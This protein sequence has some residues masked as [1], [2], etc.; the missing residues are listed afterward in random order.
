MVDEF[1]DDLYRS[2][3]E[4]TLTDRGVPR[5][6]L[7]PPL[8]SEPATRFVDVGLEQPGSGAGRVLVGD[9][10]FEERYLRRGVI[11][12][13]GMGEVVLWRDGRV[14]RDVAV[15]TLHEE[16]KGD[17]RARARFLREARVQGQLEH[18]SIVP[19]YDLRD[20]PEHGLSFTMKRVR[21]RTL[22][23]IL[24]ERRTE[25][26]SSSRPDGSTSSS[27]PTR[28]LLI[29]LSSVC[30]AI[31]FAHQRGVVH[32]D[33]KPGNVMLGD[34][35]E[36]YVLDWGLAKVSGDIDEIAG[37]VEQSPALVT[38][39]GAVLG[40]LGYMAPEQL[41]ASL[42]VVGPEADVYALGAIL[43]EILTNRPLIA[44]RDSTELALKTL[45]G[46]NANARERAPELEVPPELEDVCVQ[47]TKRF[48]SDRLASARSLHEALERYL[49][50]D[51]DTERRRALAANHVKSAQ[52]A[53]DDAGADGAQELDARATAMRELGAALALDRDHEGARGLFMELL[54]E[55]P[56]TV[57]P[58]A[59]AEMDAIN[60][61]QVREG[62]RLGVPLSLSWL[63]FFPFALL[64]EPLDWRPGLIGV[65]AMV[66]AALISGLSLMPPRVPLWTQIVWM[67]LFYTMC[68]TTSL[69]AG[70]HIVTPVLITT[71]ATAFQLHPIAAM[72]R[73]ARFSGGLLL[74]ALVV[75]ERAGLSPMSYVFEDLGTLRVLPV[76]VRFREPAATI[77]FTASVVGAM[78]VNAV[79]VGRVHRRLSAAQERLTLLVWHLK[80]LAPPDTSGRLRA[81][82]GRGAP[83]AS[84]STDVG[85]GR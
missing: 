72:R 47:A 12:R 13:G 21:G 39:A 76:S 85:G 61:A 45:A 2:S 53:L 62:A 32:R 42:G 23:D 36:V 81:A 74:I 18:P 55:P 31:D 25:A 14:G 49:E 51:R 28:R 8:S 19:V 6:N 17:A 3:D 59:R 52:R 38:Q 48:P 83:R 9:G 79:F 1:G 77:L 84:T 22:H 5:P 54:T 11:G 16:I 60:N 66:S 33:L 44:G 73:F 46:V 80:L 35:G 34:F 71:L 67:M 4:P 41:D 15:K 57:P 75:A 58:A 50:G 78:F 30:L 68:A 56:K 24:Q 40:T 82:P 26:A 69:I 20:D 63:L 27:V 64:L 7:V 65:V 29:A 10:S 70:P 43:F 37:D